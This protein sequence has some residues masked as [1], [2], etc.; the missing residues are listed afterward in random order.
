[1]TMTREQAA[2]I[3]RAKWPLSDGC[4]T[5]T[6]KPMVEDFEPLENYIDETDLA[7]GR[8]TLVC[9]NESENDDM[10]RGIRFE[11]TEPT[12][13]EPGSDDGQEMC[14]ACG[15]AELEFK[16]AS[17]RL[18]C[19]ACGHIPEPTE[20]DLELEAENEAREI[21]EA[22]ARELDA[23]IP[24]KTEPERY[25]AF[26]GFVRLRRWTESSS[27]GHK[28]VFHVGGL[29]ELK[30]F[31]KA[32][33]RRGKK[34]GQ[35]YYLI[36]ATDKGDP[37]PN[38]PDECW[39]AGADWSHQN[40]GSI[41]LVFASIDFWRLFTTA[42][43]GGDG[44][45]FHFTMVEINAQEEPVDQQQQDRTEEGRKKLA[46]G[47][48]SKHAA[49]RNTEPEFQQFVAFRMGVARDK[50]HAIGADSCDRWVKQ[51]VGIQS[52]IE[53]DHN[54]DAWQRYESLITRPYI[55]WAQSTRR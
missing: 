48:K 19:P 55:T 15:E 18:C 32:V 9:M 11:L 2:V 47:P 8:V 33:R 5:C 23:R 49:M 1:M 40:G 54:A 36:I 12:E 13:R 34:S 45:P 28:V 20:N 24:R 29:E 6:W 21:V 42:D 4:R 26:E 14:P 53:L 39:F 27:S 31:E 38:T 22:A 7:E 16:D 10:H 37:V 25:V 30:P 3:I 41:T 50:W 46:G 44:Q 43:Q 35:R 52:K 17:I 51:M